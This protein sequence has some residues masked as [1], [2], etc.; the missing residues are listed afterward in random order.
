MAPHG[1]GSEEAL[2]VQDENRKPISSILIIIAMQTHLPLLPS[3]PR[4]PFLQTPSRP[5]TPRPPQRISLLLTC[6]HP[7]SLVGGSCRGEK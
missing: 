2:V 7:I 4:H 1:E 6:T 3:S 5:N